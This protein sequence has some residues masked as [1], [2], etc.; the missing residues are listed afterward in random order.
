MCGI[1]GI[2]HPDGDPGKYI[3][4]VRQMTQAMIHRGPDEDGYYESSDIS[5]GIRRLSVI[6]LQ[7]G[8]QPITNETGTVHIIANCEIYGFETIRNKL[9]ARGHSF[10]TK[11]DTEVMLHLYEEYGLNLFS[12]IDGMFAFALWDSVNKRLIIGRDRF[13]IKPLFYSLPDARGRFAFASELQPLLFLPNQSKALDPL[14]IDMYFALSYIPHP[15]TIYESIRKLPPGYVLLA[16]G[17][18][19]KS[20]CY[21][22]LPTQS[23]FLDPA[24]AV[25]ELDSAI[26]VSV[27]RMMRSDVPIGAFLSGGL[28]SSTVVYHMSQQSS[29]PV[30]TFSLRFREKDFDEGDQARTI[31]QIMGTEHTEV[32]GKPD[33]VKIISELTRFFGEPFADPALIP[34]YLISKIAREKVTVALSGDGGDEMFG[35]YEMYYAS[36]LAE[37]AAYIPDSVRKT[38]IRIIRY[39]PASMK[40]AGI[41]YRLQKFLR[42]CRLPPIER[43]AMWKTIFT[44]SDRRK[45]YSDEFLDTLGSDIDRPVFAQWSSLFS[46]DGADDL[47]DYQHLDIKTYLTDNNLTKVDRMSM[48]NSLEVRVPL[49]DLHVVEVAQRIPHRLRINQLQTKIILRLLMQNRLPKS[50]LTMKKKG[51]AVP[52]P[53]WF[54]SHLQHYV[55]DVLSIGRVKKL[56]L[57]QPLEVQNI[58]KAHMNGKANMSRQIWNL[59]CFLHWYEHSVGE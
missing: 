16:E 13:G 33:D 4:T 36:L 11:S 14:A 18:V 35:G 10:K 29:Q 7:T 34:N 54:R 37:Y 38:L 32:W 26:S 31:S 52:L 53:L 28:D 59:L 15:Y 47:R 57:I 49:L 39:M 46:R 42:G 2:Y 43:H 9:E 6:D 5:M 50:V 27:K 44:Q 17:K 56:G 25:D 24:A 23:S 21:W 40:H 51:F 12:H 30:K 55:E 45:L 22:E 20:V 1:S 3:K 19:V 8:S 48:A 41:D 58:I